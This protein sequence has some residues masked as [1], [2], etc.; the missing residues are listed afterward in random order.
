[1][2]CEAEMAKA[3][4]FNVPGKQPMNVTANFVS[5]IVDEEYLVIGSH[6]DSALQQGII[7][8]EYIDFARL[9][10][11]DRVTK[12]DDHR[13]ELVVK[14]G[15]TYFSPIAERE[16]TIISNFSRWEQAFRIYSNVLTRA[17]PGKASE[18]IQYNHTIY[19]A[20]LSFA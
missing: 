17:Y 11:K 3:A 7:D 4:M 1:M 13:Y 5:S 2:V 12:M 6:V 20:A 15:N 19:M 9:L 14:G 16:N 10:P 18:L 8:F